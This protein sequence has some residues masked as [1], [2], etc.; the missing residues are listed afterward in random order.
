MKFSMKI[1]AIDHVFMKNKVIN[2]KLNFK[3]FE[4]HC[5]KHIRRSKA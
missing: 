4:I 5:S 3:N 2:T 1:L